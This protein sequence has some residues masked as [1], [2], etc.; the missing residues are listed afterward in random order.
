VR[1]LVALGKPIYCAGSRVNE[2]ALT[3]DDGRGPY[4]RLMLAKL[5]KR[6]APVGRAA[7]AGRRFRRQAAEP[8]TALP[9]EQREPG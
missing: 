6:A 1:R 5:R 7:V 4:A 3:F 9:I 8:A 2:V